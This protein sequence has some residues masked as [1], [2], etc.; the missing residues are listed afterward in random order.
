MRI[1][2][3]INVISQ[4]GRSLGRLKYLLLN[5]H[6]LQLG[7]LV[8]RSRRW[9][10]AHIETVVPIKLCLS[11]FKLEQLDEIRL[12]IS[13]AQF[14]TLKPYWEYQDENPEEDVYPTWLHC[15]PEA[16][17]IYHPPHSYTDFKKI[18]NCEAEL[19]HLGS[20]AHVSLSDG[21]RGRI[22]EYYLGWESTHLMPVLTS[23]VVGFPAL[24][25]SVTIPA[26][27]LKGLE[28]ERALLE[29]N[30]AE[31]TERLSWPTRLA[32]LLVQVKQEDNL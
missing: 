7:G 30:R 26:G 24:G 13:A 4:E 17:F 25:D 10:V 9:L 6:N 15:N 2:L 32:E 19:V 29:L 3:G 18:R 31:L 11:A 8:V 5:R 21:G 1:H 12:D 20:A 22:R 28:E 27:W 14:E 23:L 16:F